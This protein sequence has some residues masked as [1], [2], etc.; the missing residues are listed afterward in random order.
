MS[1]ENYKKISQWK[2]HS[3]TYCM[4]ENNEDNTYTGCKI[5][6]KKG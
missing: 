1:P 6:W 4:E 5:P 2:L 3:L